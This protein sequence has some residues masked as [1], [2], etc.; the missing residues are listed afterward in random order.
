[1]LAHKESEVWSKQNEMTQSISAKTAKTLI[2]C[3]ILNISTISFELAFMLVTSHLIRFEHT[4]C[5]TVTSVSSDLVAFYFFQVV[6]ETSAAK[7]RPPLHP[8]FY[9]LLRRH[10]LRW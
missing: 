4:A 8:L 1:M 5:D 10:L 2:L 6:R 7:A 9:H 3:Q